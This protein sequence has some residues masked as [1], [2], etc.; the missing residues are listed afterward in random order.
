MCTYFSAKVS[1]THVIEHGAIQKDIISAVCMQKNM[2]YLSLYGSKDITKVKTNRQIN[3]MIE[4][5]QIN[6]LAGQK[7]R[8]EDIK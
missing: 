8:F 4:N 3:K 1:Q 7:H 5:K 2:K 6:R